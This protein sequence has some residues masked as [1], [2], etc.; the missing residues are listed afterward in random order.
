MIEKKYL[1]KNDT[2]VKKITQD[3]IQI[4]MRYWMMKFTTGKMTSVIT[5]LKQQP[6]LYC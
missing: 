1:Q 6:P 3:L 4:R 5:L 2:A